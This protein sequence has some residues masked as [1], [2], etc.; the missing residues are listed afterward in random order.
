[1]SCDVASKICLASAAGGHATFGGAAC[2]RIARDV[3]RD[4]GRRHRR[5]HRQSD[6]ISHIEIQ[7]DRIDTVI[8][9]IDTVMLHI[10]TVILRSASISILSSCHLVDRMTRSYLVTLVIGTVK[11]LGT[12]MN[13]ADDGGGGGGVGGVA[14]EA[15]PST[16]QLWCL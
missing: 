5:C 9:H 1:M 8:S 2:T 10:V 16:R 15:R 11:V 12:V 14:R 3:Y 4:D 6:K 13:V 7:D